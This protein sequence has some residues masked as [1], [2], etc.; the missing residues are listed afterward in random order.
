MRKPDFENGIKRVLQK[1]KPSRPTL[2]EFI[3]N[4]KLKEELAG[5]KLDYNG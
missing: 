2:F 1:G 4:N 5:F 3:I